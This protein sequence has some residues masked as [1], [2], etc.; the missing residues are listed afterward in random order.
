V[1]LFSFIH[2][3]FIGDGDI[4]MAEPQDLKLRARELFTPALAASVIR[5]IEIDEQAPPRSER[6]HRQGSAQNRSQR[7]GS[8]TTFTP[9]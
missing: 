4:A 7:C 1:I 2:Q 6:G 8:A 5:E 3:H 9:V